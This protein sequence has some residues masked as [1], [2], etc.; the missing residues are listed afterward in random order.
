VTA[1]K[2]VGGLWYWARPGEATSAPS[3]QHRHTADGGGVVDG[4]AERQVRELEDS[5]ARQR[6]T[7][8]ILASAG[9]STVEAE[10]LLESMEEELEALQWKLRRD[11]RPGT[12]A[13]RRWPK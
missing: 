12:P 13:V 11:D 2:G 4:E 10:Q 9:Q 1:K 3:Q 7:V 8:R 6:E 5:I